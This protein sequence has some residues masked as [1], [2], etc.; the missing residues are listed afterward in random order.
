MIKRFLHN[1]LGRA[2][3]GA[4]AFWAC[5]ALVMLIDVIAGFDYGMMSMTFVTILAPFVTWMIMYVSYEQ[6]RAK[7][8]SRVMHSILIS[9]IGPLVLTSSAAIFIAGIPACKESSSMWD[10][11]LLL[12]LSM[13]MGTLSVL[14]YTGMLGAMAVNTI[15]SPLIGLWLAKKR[16]H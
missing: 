6:I 3:I 2:I 12:G 5:F 10:C 7:G 16:M 14:G 13:T 9:I 4:G 11:L 1:N 8:R 15:A